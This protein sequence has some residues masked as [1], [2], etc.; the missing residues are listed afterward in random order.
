MF[1]K[2]QCVKPLSEYRLSVQFIGG[3]QKEYDVKPLFDRWEVFRALTYIPGLF[4][5]VKVDSGGY[6]ISWNDQIDL[7]CDELYANGM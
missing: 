4:N 6:G 2:V 3:E 5:Q 1:H 7:A